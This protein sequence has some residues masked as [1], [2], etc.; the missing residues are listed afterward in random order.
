MQPAHPK[1]Q[2]TK[3]LTTRPSYLLLFFTLTCFF[4]FWFWKLVCLHAVCSKLILFSVISL[5]LHNEPFPSICAT[6]SY[7]QFMWREEKQPEHCWPVAELHPSQAGHGFLQVLSKVQNILHRPF[8]LG[9]WV[10]RGTHTW[11]MLTTKN[12]HAANLKMSMCV[13]TGA[14]WIQMHNK[15]FIETQSVKFFYIRNACSGPH[16]LIII[17]C[18]IHPP[19]GDI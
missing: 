1:T 16:R 11:V 7:F 12:C 3:S 5:H 19:S 10:C 2:P 15:I 8:P 6:V 4:S 17:Q 9:L 18:S 13:S 14:W